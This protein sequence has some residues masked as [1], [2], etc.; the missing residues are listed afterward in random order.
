VA[1]EGADVVM[2]GA[3]QQTVPAWWRVTDRLLADA[4]S[5][6]VILHAD[7]AGF[8]DEL[9]RDLAVE[10]R[11]GLGSQRRH[12]PVTVQVTLSALVDGVLRGRE[13]VVADAFA[14]ARR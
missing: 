13:A 14:G 7:P 12:A 1:I 11:S 5:R 3:W 4:G 6:A 10:P 2:V 9:D 8:G